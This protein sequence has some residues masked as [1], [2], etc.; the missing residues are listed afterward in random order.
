MSKQRITHT[1]WLLAALS[2]TNFDKGERQLHELTPANQIKAKAHAKDLI[3][4]YDAANDR[5]ESD[6]LDNPYR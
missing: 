6:Y 4:K 2:K 1:G 3:A 5:N